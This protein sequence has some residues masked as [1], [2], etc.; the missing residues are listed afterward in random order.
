MKAAVLIVVAI[1]CVIPALAEN[2]PLLPMYNQYGSSVSDAAPL[3]GNPTVQDSPYGGKAYRYEAAQG[4]HVTIM[5]DGT[6][7][8]KSCG[9]ICFAGSDAAE[10]LAQAVTSCYYIGG[11]ESGL[12]CY[13]PILYQFM[14]CRAGRTPEPEIIGDFVCSTKTADDGALIFFAA[15]PNR[16]R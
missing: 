12:V 6:G 9:V 14:E 16:N 2:A 4:I 15:D 7:T 8:V 1:L 11:I 10:F 3:E 13:E 5:T